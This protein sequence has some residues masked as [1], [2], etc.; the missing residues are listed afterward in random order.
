MAAAKRGWVRFNAEGAEKSERVAEG[1]LVNHER[2]QRHEVRPANCASPT[3]L[4]SEPRDVHPEAP[5]Y[6]A[7]QGGDQ[8]GWSNGLAARGHGCHPFRGERLSAW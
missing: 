1:V 5:I 3:M 8:S 2:H 6:A 4:S 7:V